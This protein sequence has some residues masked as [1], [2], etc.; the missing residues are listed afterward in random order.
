MTSDADLFRA[1]LLPCRL[2]DA[3]TGCAG[4]WF[5]VE[6][7]EAAMMSQLKEKMRGSIGGGE[8]ALTSLGF[9]LIGAVRISTSDDPPSMVRS[10]GDVVE[11][12][13]KRCMLILRHGGAST[14]R[15]RIV[16]LKLRMGYCN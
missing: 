10:S 16:Y 12:R 3:S 13:K 6:E 1:L 2:L 14:R 15:R 5:P 9:L 11:G 4:L 8:G 7:D